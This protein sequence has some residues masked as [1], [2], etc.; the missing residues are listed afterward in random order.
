MRMRLAAND[1]AQLLAHVPHPRLRH[2]P[3]RRHGV[4]VRDE[5]A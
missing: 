1:H 2:F 4:T 3:R 5:A